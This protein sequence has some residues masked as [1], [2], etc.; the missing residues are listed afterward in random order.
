[1]LTRKRP[2]RARRPVFCLMHIEEWF[3]TISIG[4]TITA[5]VVSMTIFPVLGGMAIGIITAWRAPLADE[6]QHQAA[7]AAAVT[8]A[9]L[10]VGLV[11]TVAIGL[12]FVAYPAEM[13]RQL[14]PLAII[15]IVPA[16][17]FSELA[18]YCACVTAKVASV[19]GARTVTIKIP[20]TIIATPKKKRR[21]CVS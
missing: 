14:L 15:A 20:P 16:A 21:S 10:V 12:F 5:N 6:T 11:L 2:D 1:M 7:L 18:I 13:G 3:K 8:G 4:S 9:G 17:R 19:H